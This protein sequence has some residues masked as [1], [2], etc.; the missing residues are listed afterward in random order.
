P[1]G[2]DGPGGLP[3]CNRDCVDEP[4]YCVNTQYTTYTC[5][6]NCNATAPTG[7]TVVQGS[8]PTVANLSWT[9]GT[10]GVSQLL[11]V[12]ED[13]AEVNNGCPTPGDCVVNT[14]IT[15]FT[16]NTPYS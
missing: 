4:A 8:S 6:S 13:L 12:D 2:N 11:R 9:S 1:C 14:S 5:V 3:K 16:A 15:P 7:L 10:N